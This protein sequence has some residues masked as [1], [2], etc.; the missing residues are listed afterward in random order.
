ML[1]RALVHLV[2]CGGAGSSGG[3]AGHRRAEARRRTAPGDTFSIYFELLAVVADLN[4]GND[5]VRMVWSSP[6]SR[7]GSPGLMGDMADEEMRPAHSA[8]MASCAGH[9]SSETLCSISHK[10]RKN[11]LSAG[12]HW[13][14]T[15]DILAPLERSETVALCAHGL[16]WHFKDL[17]NLPSMSD[18]PRVDDL[19]TVLFITHSAMLM[20]LTV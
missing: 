2:S 8:F 19:L 4:V 18:I 5:R 3:G 7:H 10:K 16:R 9:I 17:M 6:G 20:S 1:G 15:H 12:C 13:T 14:E 11:E